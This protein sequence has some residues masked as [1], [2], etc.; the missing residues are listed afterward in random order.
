MCCTRGAPVCSRGSRS[1]VR[2]ER[3]KVSLAAGRTRRRMPAASS[4]V[5]RGGVG[6]VAASS[7]DHTTEV[8]LGV[9]W[10]GGTR[11]VAAACRGG[12]EVRFLLLFGWWCLT[13]MTT[14]EWPNKFGDGVRRN[15]NGG[16]AVAATSE[17]EW[18]AAAVVE[19]PEVTAAGEAV[20]LP[21]VGCFSGDSGRLMIL[22]FVSGVSDMNW[23]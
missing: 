3:T 20:A 23:V 4:S 10:R 1:G 19:W 6:D 8:G 13:T 11:S 16:V 14:V 21:E 7:I 2:R 9:C 18:G 12:D 22:S 15:R 5:R 17:N